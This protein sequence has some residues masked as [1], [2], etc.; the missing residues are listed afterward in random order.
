MTA[1]DAMVASPRPMPAGRVMI[2]LEPV[3]HPELEPIHIQ[4]NLFAIGRLEAPFDNY[5]EGL[6]ADLSRR[7]A[8]IFCE[9]GTVYFA[10]LGSKNGSSVNGVPVKQAIRTLQGG[11]LLGLGKGLTYRVQL[12]P[13]AMPPPHA[14]LSRLIMLPDEGGAGLQP[15]VVTEFPFMV[16]KADATFAR[17]K[18]LEPAQVNYLSR[19]HAHIFLKGGGLHVED[20]GSTNGTFVNGVR[21]EEHAVALHDGDLIAFG[22]RH[23]VYRIALEWEAA[24]RDP[25]LTRI[26]AAV[27]ATAAPAGLDADRTTFVAAADSFL[28]IF[29]VDAASAPAGEAAG[30]TDP[31]APPQAAA[32]GRLRRRALAIALPL[33]VLAGVLYQANR[34]Q[35][36]VEGLLADKAYGQAAA[37]A[38]EALADDPG[39]RRLASLGTEAVLKAGLPPWMAALEAGRFEE[40]ARQ[41][42]AMRRQARHN[43]ELAPLMDELDW[44]VGLKSFIAARGGAQ[45]PGSN[46]GDAAR[47]ERILKQW[48]EQGEA[49]QRAFETMSAHVPAFRDAYAGALSDVRRLALARG[50]RDAAAMEEQP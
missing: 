13:A 45:A 9:H 33:V 41:A 28:D 12:E 37:L 18:E 29:C 5:P 4:E 46:P 43:P 47:I 27:P 14:R 21:L 23:F 2:V 3:S 31:A 49:H 48:E 22:G 11:D 19:R 6:A 42:A 8:R 15:I 7:H 50:S 38:S 1:A 35:R 34:P 36:V 20:L 26:G 16:S 10:D 44:I 39:N 32:P 24:A 25:T 17:Y 40:A 30:R